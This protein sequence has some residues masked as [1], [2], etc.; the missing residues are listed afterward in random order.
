M[1]F[2]FRYHIPRAYLK[3]RNNFLV[4]YEESSGTIDGVMINTVNRDV[5]CSFMYEDYPPNLDSWTIENDVLKAVVDKPKPEAKLICDPQKFIKEIQ[6]ASFGNPW[7]S[8][9]TYIQGTCQ[10]PNAKKVVEKV[11]QFRAKFVINVSY[12][13]FKLD[14]LLYD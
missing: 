11:N 13:T 3:P 7:G 6:F 8:C 1:H 4:V 2:H 14:I 10:A 12:Y 9:G 5:I